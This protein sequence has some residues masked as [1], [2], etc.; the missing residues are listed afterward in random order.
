MEPVSVLFFLPVLGSGGAEMNAVRL[1]AGL[2]ANG[3][4]PAYAVA[5]GPGAYAEHLPPGVEELILPTGTSTS[6]TVRMLRAIRPLAR[7]IDARRPDCLCPVMVTPALV[8][9]AALR[10]ARHRPRLVVSIQNTLQLPAGT[11]WHPDAAIENYLARRAFPRVDGVIALSHGVGQ[12]VEAFIPAL[13]GRV[14]VIHNVGVPLGTQVARPEPDGVPARRHPVR[15][16]AC[17]RLARQK[18]YPY[19]LEA[20]ARVVPRVDAELH[21]LGDGPDRAALE[22]LAGRL[23]IADRVTFLGFRRNPFLHMQAADVFVLAS[24]WEGFAN[25]IV[26]AMSMGTAVVAADCP[27]GPSEIIRDGETGLLVPPANAPALADAMV[28]LG[29]D[30]SLRQRIATAGQARS[31]DFSPQRIAAQFAAA[32]RRLAGVGA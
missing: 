15:Y 28:R 20:F 31:A 32:F 29:G 26:E 2:V 6:S 7:L 10:L 12:H 24:L 22:A 21:I 27:Y 18:G 4:Q 3:V 23:G 17:G 13:A 11:G 5:R 14:E 25:V 1:A 30:A 19:L 16:L 9:L 8:A